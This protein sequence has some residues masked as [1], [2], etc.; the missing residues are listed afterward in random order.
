[1]ISYDTCLHVSDLL[2]SLWQSLGPSMLFYLALFHSFYMTISRSIYVAANGIISFE[3]YICTLLYL[4]WITIKDLLY[5]TGN[6]AQCYVASWMG[7]EF[8]GERL[9][10]YV[11]LSPFTVNLTLSQHCW[12][13]GYAYVSNPEKAMAPHSST[14][15]WE[16]PLMEEP[17]RL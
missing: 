2:H 15:A 1:M 12:L 16:I 9:Y 5:S 4:E 11:W 8:G 7:E 6:S 17:G 10:V 14:L 13:I 3:I